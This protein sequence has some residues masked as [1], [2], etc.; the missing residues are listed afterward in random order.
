MLPTPPST[1]EIGQ[2]EIPHRE[3]INIRDFV[4]E[5]DHNDDQLPAL[6]EDDDSDD[7]G[8]QEEREDGDEGQEEEAT[9]LRE[10]V[11]Q[12]P[13]PQTPPNR[14]RRRANLFCMARKPYQDPTERHYL[15]YG[16]TVPRLWGTTLA[17][18]EV[19][20]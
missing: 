19:C 7:E 15:G 17:C 14:R 18:R 20:V 11:I 16:C 2:D 4:Q 3:E 12:Q 9:N 6:I 13:A 8:N 5:E 10:R 1:Q